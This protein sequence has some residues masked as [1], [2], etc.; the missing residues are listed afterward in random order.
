MHVCNYVL[1]KKNAVW[2]DGWFFV[3][4]IQKST[5]YCIHNINVKYPLR[6]L[7]FRSLKLESHILAEAKLLNKQNNEDKYNESTL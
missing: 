6:K 5:I 1:F 7:L 3:C 4:C 2:M